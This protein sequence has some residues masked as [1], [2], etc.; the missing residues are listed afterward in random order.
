MTKIRVYE[1]AKELSSAARKLS[2]SDVKEKATELGIVIDGHLS[3]LEE[4]DAARIR[5]AFQVTPDSGQEKRVRNTVVRRR[6]VGEG[7]G[8]SVEVTTTTTIGEEPAEGAVA[9][10][11]RVVRRRTRVEPAAGDEAQAGIPAEAGTDQ[12][13]MAAQQAPVE[14]AAEGTLA[15]V[16]DAGDALQAV[17]EVADGAVEPPPAAEAE[18]TPSPEAEV[19]DGAEPAPE[20]VAAAKAP[21]EAPPAQAPQP[22]PPGTPQLVPTVRRRSRGRE[23]FRAVVVALPEITETP[24]PAP[25]V[26]IA[27]RPGGVL[28]PST[29][30]IDKDE[31]SV[32]PKRRGK[33]LIYDRRREGAAAPGAQLDR[34]GRPVRVK[35]KKGQRG[36]ES[37]ISSTVQKRTVQIDETIS[38]GDMAAQMAVKASVVLRKLFEQNIL[39]T[40]NDKLDYETAA[41]IAGDLGYEVENTSFDVGKYLISEEDKAEDLATR[42]PVVTIMGHVD[43]GKT[44]LLDRIQASDIA[45]G[46]AGGITQ[47][48]GAYVVE[49]AKGK[50]TFIDT[51]GHEAFTAMRARGAQV[52]DLVI[53]VVA[54]DDGVM[55]QTLEAIDHARAAK[56]PIIVAVNKVDKPEADTARVRRELADRELVP[57]EWGGDTIYVDVSARTGAGIDKLLDMLVLQSEVLELKANADKRASGI[58]IESRL[59]K[60]RGPVASVVV[61]DGTLKI[62]DWVVAGMAQGRVRSL[63]DHKGRSLKQVTPGM[64]AEIIGLDRVPQAGETLHVVQ[65]EKTSRIVA[66]YKEKKERDERLAR[67][68]KPSF[69]QLFAQVPETDVKVLK[70][71]LKGDTQGSMEA[72]RQGMEQIHTE[73]VKLEVIGTGVGVISESDVNLARASEGLIL[74]FNI[75]PDA[76][77]KTLADSLGVE[78]LT[79]NLIHELIDK[80]RLLMEGKLE[81][82]EKEVY[83]GKAEVRQV[84][85]ISRIGKIA[86][87]HVL[88]GRVLRSALV[89]VKRND[90]MIWQGKLSS[91]KRFKDDVKEVAQGFECGMSADGFDG[92]REGDVIEA[93]EIQKVAATLE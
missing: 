43:H 73:K 90:E 49:V 52:T 56:V 25:V 93:F 1:L 35:R 16:G 70:V 19:A 20:E 72:I 50:V 45:S 76:K 36:P 48:I 23:E 21:S 89:R 57:E 54:A 5:R 85:S 10:S 29:R 87:C 60:G 51:P 33:R 8:A 22:A 24:K 75:R 53:L 11:A 81:M 44:S 88:E 46:E 3:Y 42:P 91:L 58:I 26:P 84:F 59:E 80:T 92:I 86:G 62:G 2:A 65:D 78:I 74:G 34:D 27:A 31:D 17:T 4:A 41:I 69:E 63:N 47:K 28:K 64:P 71:V 9:K 37:E 83:L 77:A 32:R 15:D 7:D 67:V 66:D 30:E 61:R 38:V 79:F 6:R 82:V 18:A 14:A 13:D 68:R 55:P 12:A 40:V 39:V